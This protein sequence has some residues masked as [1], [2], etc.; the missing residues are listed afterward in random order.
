MKLYIKIGN[1]IFDYIILSLLLFVA[2]LLVVPLFA[3]MVSVIAFYENESIKAMIKVIKEN[4]KQIFVLTV[5]M[6][7]L[8]SMILLLLQL[9]NTGILAV[10]NRIVL[11]VI[12]LM[13]TLLIIYPPMILIKMNVS[14]KELLRNTIYLA[15]V[16]YKSTLLM[17][18]L[19]GLMIYLSIYAIWAL[20]LVVPWLQSISY[21]SNKALEIEKDK[22]ERG[23]KI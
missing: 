13:M 4:L 8:G 7:F 15:L 14:T 1:Y 19:T 2:G 3:V 12:L 10:F 22:R 18:L 16:Q 21:I 5:I 17:L 9:D 6:L 23:E 20:I 11:V